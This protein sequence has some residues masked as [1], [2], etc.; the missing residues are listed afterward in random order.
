MVT[1]PQGQVLVSIYKAMRSRVRRNNNIPIDQRKSEQP[2]TFLEFFRAKVALVLLRQFLYRHDL[3]IFH[4][5][6][7]VMGHNTIS[8]LSQTVDLCF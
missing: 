1:K 8:A 4:Y 5:Y 6:G 2:R 7:L 3:A